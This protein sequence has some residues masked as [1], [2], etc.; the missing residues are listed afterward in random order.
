[1]PD[2]GAFK[3]WEIL[4][5]NNIVGKIEVTKSFYPPDK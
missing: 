1:M 3:M 4:I 5:N 2:Y